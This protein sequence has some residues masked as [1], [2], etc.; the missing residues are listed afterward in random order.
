LEIDIFED[1]EGGGSVALICIL[2]GSGSCE[3]AGFGISGVDPWGSVTRALIIFIL[4]SAM[5]DI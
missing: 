1:R 5:R 4:L 2:R 3:M